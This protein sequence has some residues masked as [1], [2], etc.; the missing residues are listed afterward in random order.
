[1][2]SWFFVCLLW[3]DSELSAVG[4]KVNHHLSSNSSPGVFSLSGVYEWGDPDAAHSSSIF[5]Q[6][7]CCF[8]QLISCVPWESQAKAC[9]SM[10]LWAELDHYNRNMKYK[11]VNHF[12]FSYIR[13]CT[14]SDPGSS[15]YNPRQWLLKV[16]VYFS[17][18]T[19]RDFLGVPFF[20]LQSWDETAWSGF[21]YL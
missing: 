20:F 19:C 7:P 13:L 14:E 9:M 11:T 15:Y 16:F 3:Q 5:S 4:K 6:W 17:D 18:L 21:P 2:F 12:F 8:R 1:M 10:I